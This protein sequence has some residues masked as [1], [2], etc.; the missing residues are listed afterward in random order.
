[1][2]KSKSK[3]ARVPKSL[4]EA[5]QLAMT[6]SWVDISPLVQVSDGKFQREEAMLQSDVQHVF[7]VLTETTMSSE[8]AQFLKTVGPELGH[9]AD[10]IVVSDLEFVL[11]FRCDN[12]MLSNYKENPRYIYILDPYSYHI[13]RTLMQRGN[14]FV[15]W[16][17]A[18]RFILNEIR[19]VL[20]DDMAGAPAVCREDFW[21]IV[22]I[23]MKRVNEK[24][25][26]NEA[27]QEL[28]SLYAPFSEPAYRRGLAFFSQ[29]EFLHGLIKQQ[30]A[31]YAARNKFPILFADPER[32]VFIDDNI[33]YINSAVAA[34]W[35]KARTIHLD[36]GIFSL[37]R[38]REMIDGLCRIV[39]A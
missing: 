15:F 38:A 10:L 17:S 32:G 4:K 29:Q 28:R 26:D 21:Q 22:C 3:Q 33:D 25:S 23:F 18:L 20:P 14:E 39:P 13:Y 1:M 8:Y 24:L 31:V 12:E 16:T 5:S 9:I 2:M 27:M 6:G 34:G 36:P 19:A 11:V 35:P 30:K 7:D 37:Q